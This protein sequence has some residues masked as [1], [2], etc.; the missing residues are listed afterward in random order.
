MIAVEFTTVDLWLIVA[1]A[2][3]MF[4]ASATALAETAIVRISRAKA[5]GMAEEMY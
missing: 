2:I 4:I 5:T 3:L 1:I